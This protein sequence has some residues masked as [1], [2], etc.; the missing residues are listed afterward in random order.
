MLLRLYTKVK[1]FSDT[2]MWFLL[3]VKTVKFKNSRTLDYL[4][5]MKNSRPIREIINIAIYTN[6]LA[7]SFCIIIIKFH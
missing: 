2:Q 5:K 4:K 3:P 7:P 6:I 1:Q